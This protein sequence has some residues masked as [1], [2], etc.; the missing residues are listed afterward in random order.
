[1][2]FLAG[3]T[4]IPESIET[5]ET[6]WIMDETEEEN[7]ISEESIMDETEEE[8]EI[9]EESI[10][11]ETGEEINE[12]LLMEKLKNISELWELWDR[13][14]ILISKDS[15]A[16]SFAKQLADSRNWPLFLINTNDPNE[17]RQRIVNYYKQ[18]PFTFLLII[19]TQ[20]EIPLNDENFLINYI[21]K[22]NFLINGE[23]LDQE[24]NSLDSFYY[25]NIDDDKFIELA[26]GRLPFSDLK[27]IQ[28]YYLKIPSKKT[29]NKIN[30]VSHASFHVPHI[31]HLKPQLAQYKGKYFQMI[32]TVNE[33][34]QN[35]LNTDLLYS[36][37][38]GSSDL[39]FIGEPYSKNDI[40]ILQN[41]QIIIGD[42]CSAGENLG[43]EF[44]KKGA[45]AY[46]G[47]SLQAKTGGLALLDTPSRFNTIGEMINEVNNFY[48]FFTQELQPGPRSMYYLIG[49][50]SLEVNFDTYS[51]NIKIND[52]G[53]ELEI[54]LSPMKKYDF[55][56]TYQKV[57]NVYLMYSY[58]YSSSPS[59]LELLKK[60]EPCSYQACPSCEKEI[61]FKCDP[62]EEKGSLGG[63]INQIVPNCDFEYTITYVVTDPRYKNSYSKIIIRVDKSFEPGK[64]FEYIEGE[65]IL[66]ENSF[67]EI[68]DTGANYYLVIFE[69]NTI[70]FDNLRTNR[71]YNERKI[72][73]EKLN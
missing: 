23:L 61:S 12:Q 30:V 55:I 50:P 13:G 31:G 15:N 69:P 42:S 29:I 60:N 53:D 72:A 49:D 46:I 70:F 11:D 37:S 41:H 2:L 64:V 9:S 21:N 39:F 54:V 17:I 43:P 32:N 47:Y 25:S 5:I 40:P 59:T 52:V 4:T 73:I 27:D 68:F 19:G 20:E 44:I 24:K 26:V 62:K 14:L 45:S 65:K 67:T 34:N 18:K 36:N 28:N 38:H 35:L 51:D 56:T 16:L 7:E 57:R 22:Q 10:M 58:Q 6:I 8:N 71:V 33:F 1:M 66:F 3:C 63:C 48:I